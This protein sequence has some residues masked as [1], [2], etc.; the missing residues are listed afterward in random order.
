MTLRTECASRTHDRRRRE[1]AIG[2]A[3]GEVRQESAL[4]TPWGRRDRDQGIDLF[5]SR[6]SDVT[7]ETGGDSLSHPLSDHRRLLSAIDV[8]ELFHDDRLMLTVIASY[9]LGK[10]S[11][12]QIRSNMKVHTVIASHLSLEHEVRM[13]H[14]RVVNKYLPP[15]PQEEGGSGIEDAQG[16]EGSV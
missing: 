5:I 9:V 13:I 12:F 4:P 1:V 16:Q 11:Q 8:L 6:K 15:S 10:Y 3:L 7:C 14:S 2:G